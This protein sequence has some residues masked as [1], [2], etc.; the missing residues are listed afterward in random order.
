MENIVVA[1]FGKYSLLQVVSKLC[2]MKLVTQSAAGLLQVRSLP[3]FSIMGQIVSILDLWT[4][5]SFLQL[6][7]SAIVANKWP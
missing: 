5:Q 6:F 7:S 3:I 1:V 4:I 2:S